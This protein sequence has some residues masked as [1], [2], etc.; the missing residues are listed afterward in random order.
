MNENNH[1]LFKGTAYY[2]SRFRRGYPEAFFKH[3]VK[4]FNLDSNSRALDLGTG[5]GQIAI[6]LSKIA[7][8]VI[9]VDPDIEM[10]NE[11]KL[12]A[13]KQGVRNITWLKVVAEDLP[14]KIGN[15][16]LTTMGASF[17]WMEQD[18]VLRNIYDITN[19]NGGICIVSNTTSIYRN[20]N[21][22]KWKM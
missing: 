19:D 13:N 4:S 20:Q 15:F 22:D 5:T 12:Q 8:E 6:S 16:E 11:G 14:D 3:L 2:Y 21:N 10:L 1:I 7:K 9:A 17:H 18:K